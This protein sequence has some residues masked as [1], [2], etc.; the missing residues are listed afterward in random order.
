MAVF[1]A[2]YVISTCSRPEFREVHK[3]PFN[4]NRY[5]RRGGFLGNP[6]N[7]PVLTIFIYVG[8]LGL[9][10]L[11]PNRI[12]VIRCGRFGHTGFFTE[13]LK[14]VTNKIAVHLY[15][16][17]EMILTSRNSPNTG[18]SGDCDGRLPAAEVITVA[19]C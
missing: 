18:S 8:L 6:D 12:I 10:K 15:A 19:C 14:T 16:L 9:C 4:I 5:E 17:S 1:S 2:V 13:I 7:F 3:K 11:K